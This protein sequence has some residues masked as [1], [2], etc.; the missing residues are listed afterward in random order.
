MNIAYLLVAS[1][2]VTL[3]TRVLYSDLV[4]PRLS[5]TWKARAALLLGVVGAAL[6][7]AVE[8]RP[9][10]EALTAGILVGASSIG[11]YELD[12]GR[13]APLLKKGAPPDGA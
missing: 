6:G 8:G 3:A 10:H 1:A 4:A 13:A 5:P 2:S 7:V 11:I 12:K 9:W